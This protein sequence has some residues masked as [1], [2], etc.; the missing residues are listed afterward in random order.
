MPESLTFIGLHY[1]A[2]AGHEFDQVAALLAPEYR[3]LAPDLGGFGSAPAPPD[4]FT[5]AAYADAVAGFIAAECPS[6]YV[7]VGHSMGGKIA[8]ELAARQP[9]GLGGVVLLSPSPP[10]PEPMTDED[11]QTSLHAWGNPQEAEKTARHITV[12][13]LPEATRRQVVADNLASSR[14]AW[15]AWLLHGS[16]ENISARMAR[17]EVPCALV[18]GDQDPVLSPSVH[19]L[20]TLPLLPAG[21]P[22]EIV[23]GAGH[24]LPYEAPEEVAALLH[25]F[26]QEWGKE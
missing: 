15:E 1:W 11:R 22:L 17:I 8:L 14:A 9:A 6:R 12:K 16:R 2:G 3:L 23:A 18:A 4:G 24:L 10:S 25:R 20:E 19:G 13:P 5:V 7:L 26:A 21:T